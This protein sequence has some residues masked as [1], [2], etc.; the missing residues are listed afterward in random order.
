M[1]RQSSNNV[2]MLKIATSAA[3]HTTKLATSERK[4]LASMRLG[5]PSAENPRC[6]TALVLVTAVVSFVRRDKIASED[7]NGTRLTN[8]NRTV[9][10]RIKIVAIHGPR[11]GETV[12]TRDIDSPSSDKR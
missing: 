7:M 9:K 8:K 3:K 1:K 10:A 2:K 11:Y 12:S 5:K 6:F 4:S